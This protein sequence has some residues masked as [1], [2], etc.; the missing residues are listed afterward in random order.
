MAPVVSNTGAKVRG[1]FPL[2]ATFNVH[3]GAGSPDTR[4]RSLEPPARSDDHPDLSE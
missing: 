3:Q 2:A 1:E 4:L